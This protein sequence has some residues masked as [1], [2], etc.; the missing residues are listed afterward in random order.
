MKNIFVSY[1]HKDS[2][3]L[4]EFLNTFSDSVKEHEIQVWYDGNIFIIRLKKSSSMKK[5]FLRYKIKRSLPI[6][7][8]VRLLF[9]F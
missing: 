4:K 2:E 1:S 6:F 7:L 8:N 3:C 9:L 5:R